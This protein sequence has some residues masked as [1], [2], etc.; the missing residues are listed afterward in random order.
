MLADAEKLTGQKYD[1]SNFADVTEAIHAIQEQWDI[2]GTTAKEGSTTLEG[3]INQAKAA[4]E[5]WL[6][7][8]GDENADMTQLTSNLVDA[9]SNAASLAMPKI[10]E[11]VGAFAAELPGLLQ[12]GYSFV[13]TD[14]LPSLGIEI[15]PETQAAIESIGGSLKQMAEATIPAVQA[16][17][18]TMAPYVAKA[19]EVAAPIVQDFADLLVNDI[20]PAIDSCMQ[21][22]GE[23]WEVVKEQTTGGAAQA[24]TSLVSL[25]TRLGQMPQTTVQ[26][27]DAVANMNGE[28]DT[29]LSTMDTR[30]GVTG[31]ELGLLGDA[32]SGAAESGTMSLGTLDR[33]SGMSQEQ[34]QQFAQGVHNAMTTA[35]QWLSQ[36]PGKASAAFNGMVSSARSGL[37]SLKTA[38][39]TALATVKGFFSNLVLKI[40]SIQMPHIPTFHVSW[41]SEVKAGKNGPS[42]TVPIP[43]IYWNALGGVFEQPIIFGNQGFGEAGPEAALPLS[44]PRAMG[45]IADAITD[46]MDTRGGNTINLYAYGVNDP[47]QLINQ[48]AGGLRQLNMMGA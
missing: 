46:R 10:K 20:L 27:S 5:N 43:H 33:A 28:V 36:L 38:V 40:P 25:D 34:M 14:L 22:F 42:I 39:Q 18:E 7:G 26:F 1:I 44:N 11:I 8:L 45:M 47:N 35:G 15:S 24:E 30:F 9:V 37:N 21:S 17:F 3:S 4:W 32:F 13:M 16:A 29:N 19:F 12:Q 23:M 48:I 31:D 41:G 6:T 2:T